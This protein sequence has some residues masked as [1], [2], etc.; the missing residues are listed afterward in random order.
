MKKRS[1]SSYTWQLRKRSSDASLAAMDEEA[2]Y[3]NNLFLIEGSGKITQRASSSLPTSSTVGE[4][5]PFN[6]QYEHEQFLIE[7][8]HQCSPCTS[9]VVGECPSI[10]LHKSPLPSSSPN[11]L[12]P[13]MVDI[14]PIVTPSEEQD[15]ENIKSVV[16]GTIPSYSFESK[17]GD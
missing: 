12:L 13:N 15:N 14:V 3:N 9:I 5:P 17:L 11:V 16:V 10:P 1:E 8:D 7:E 6:Y 4:C 2:M